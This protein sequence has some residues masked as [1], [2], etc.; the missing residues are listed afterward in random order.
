MKGILG[1]RP[2][3][4][5][6]LALQR[7]KLPENAALVELFRQRLEET[8]QSLTAAEEPVRI[9]RLQ[10]RAEVLIAILDSIEK[11]SELLERATK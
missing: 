9:Y 4:Q 8:K 11:S 3:R 6:I 10:G 7:C 5:Q 1:V 2:D